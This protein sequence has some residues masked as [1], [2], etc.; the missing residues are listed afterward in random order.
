[1]SDAPR[2]SGRFQLLLIAAV[3]IGPL[4]VAAW[5]YSGGSALQ[6]TGRS[7]HGAL[8]EP[9]VNLADE[10]PGSPIAEQY[11]NTWVLL[12]VNGNACGTPCRDALYTYRQARLM[13]GKE[14]DRITRVF[15][16]GETPPDTVFL[17]EEHPGLITIEDSGLE[18]LLDNKKP[19]DVPAGGYFL[20]D[21]L[22]NLV[23]YFRPD[24]DPAEMV[25]DIKH[26]LR[27]SRIG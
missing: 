24:L 19:A 27:L 7:N 22:G 2:K 1:M 14:M 5:L 9:I 12:Y 17:A 10:L 11:G 25:D 4:I 23:M 15:L 16:H 13:L 21:P 8:L 3:F 26:L 18:S 20:I 6:P